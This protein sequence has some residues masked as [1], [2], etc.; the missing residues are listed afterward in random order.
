MMAPAIRNN[1]EQSQYFCRSVSL[2]NLNLNL[3][4]I[5]GFFIKPIIACPTED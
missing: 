3:D 4:F 5:F 1:K 2:G